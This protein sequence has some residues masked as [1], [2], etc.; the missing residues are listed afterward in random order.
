MWQRK[1]TVFLVLAALLAMATWAFPVATYERAQDHFTFRTNGLF[2]A[3]GKAI[4]EVGL[5]VPFHIV[6]TVIGVALLACVLLYA[7]RPRQ[8]RFV[9]GTYLITLATIAF[10]FI[11]DNSIHTFLEPGGAVVN[12]YGVSFFLPL[13]TL[14]FSFLA[15]RAIRA[16]EALV[17]SADRLR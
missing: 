1:Q 2:D 7:N 17:R 16:D 12:H 5:K 4:E 3:G 8:I 14:I 13:G 10:L 9:R 15:E 6:L 11:T